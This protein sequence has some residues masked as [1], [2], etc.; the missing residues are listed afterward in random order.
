MTN[1]PIRICGVPITGYRI[2]IPQNVSPCIQYCAEELQKY[3]GLAYGAQFSICDDSTPKADHEIAISKTSRGDALS[4]LDEEEYE[5]SVSNGLVKIIGGSDRGTLYGIYGFLERF[6]GWR[7]FS[8]D[9]EVL[10]QPHMSE[11]YDGDVYRKKP[12]YEYRNCMFYEANQFPVFKAKLGFNASINKKYSE[13]LGGGLEYSGFVHTFNALCPPKTYFEEHPEYFS[14]VDGKRQPTQ[15]CLTNPEVL[16]IVINNAL[17]KLRTNKNTFISISQNDNTDYCQCPA[18]KAIDEEE[19]SPSG[20]LL[21]FVNKVAEAIEKEFPDVKVDTLAYTYTR[22]L[23][24]LTRPRHNV[25]I[26]LCSIE[27]CFR[28]PLTDTPCS[29][30][31]GFCNDI[32][33]W[34]S[35]CDKLYIWDY[36]TDFAH[37]SLPFPNYG[38]LRQ[39]NE[40]YAKHNVAGMLSQGNYNRRGADMNEFKTYL[41]SKLYKDPF[42]SAEEYEYHVCDFLEGYYGKGWENIRKYIDIL[43]EESRNQHYDC[44]FDAED[45]YHSLYKRIDEIYSLFDNALALADE[46]QA[47]HIKTTRLSVTNVELSVAKNIAENNGEELSPEYL[48]KKRKYFEDCKK[49]GVHLSEHF[50]YADDIEEAMNFYKI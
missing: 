44:Y 4:P 2:V 6:I 25:V 20:T 21:R 29:D 45:N 9:T 1:N 17:E 27:C 41:F 11:L 10:R 40:F 8:L 28:H 23:P 3:L 31:L 18:C 22:K 5:I 30:N 24:K 43:L 42:M 39:N 37:Y 13:M 26:R 15:L 50:N 46:K 14:L 19:G 38:V 49:Y 12:Y 35:I 16:Q 32:N 7:W 47:D 36:C 33:D 34:S 48:A